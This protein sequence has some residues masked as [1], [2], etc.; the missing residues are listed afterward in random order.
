MQH[1][2]PGECGRV[3]QVVVFNCYFCCLAFLEMMELYYKIV[4]FPVRFL[5]SRGPVWYLE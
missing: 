3:L 1:F 2:Y 4:S 5:R